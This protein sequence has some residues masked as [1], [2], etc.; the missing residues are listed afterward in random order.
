MSKKYLL[1]YLAALLVVSGCVDKPQTQEDNV[2]WNQTKYEEYSAFYNQLLFD[3]N[4]KSVSDEKLM[5]RLDMK[6]QEV[7]RDTEF[8][9]TWYLIFHNYYKGINT[10][11]T[12]KAYQVIAVE[13]ARIERELGNTMAFPRSSAE[14]KEY[15]NQSKTYFNKSL[16]YRQRIEEMKPEGG[17]N[18]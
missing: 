18:G 11:S 5:F 8:E 7:Q 2:G 14:E 3:Y 13:K 17:K 4:N 16:E 1:L 12:A 15:W 6:L 9:N 10:F